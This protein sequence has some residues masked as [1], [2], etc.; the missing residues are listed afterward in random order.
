MKRKGNR[1]RGSIKRG[2]Q[3]RRKRR[4]HA[5]PRRLLR[6]SG[7]GRRKGRKGRKGYRRRLARA[8]TRKRAE[9]KGFDAVRLRAGNELFKQQLPVGGRIIDWFREIFKLDHDEFLW[10]LYRQILQREPDAAGFQDHKQRLEDGTAKVWI[11]ASLIQSQEAESVFDRGPSGEANTAAHVFQNL[12]PAAELDFIHAAHVHLLQREPE[13]ER[14]ASYAGALRQGLQRRIWIARLL[15]SDEAQSLLVGA[16]APAPAAPR[17]SGQ[18]RNIGI[19]LCFGSQISMDG[20]GIG[21]FIVR[22]SE[23]LLALDKG[24][25]LHVTTTEANFKETSAVFHY[26]LERYKG[27]VHIHHSDSMDMINRNVPA[28]V[29]IVPYIGMALAQYL[30]KPT[31]IC[32][33]DLVYLHFPELYAGNQ[34]HYQ[35][36]HAIAQKITAKAAA[37]VFDSE[38]TRRHEGHKFLSLP[39]HQTT[40]IRFAAPREEYSAFGVVSEDTIR[41]KYKLYGPYMVFPSVIRLHKNHERLIDAFHRFRLTEIGAASGLKLVFTDVLANRP[42]QQEI[43]AALNAIGDPGIRTSIQFLGRIP[44]GELPSLYKYASGTIVPTLFEGSCPFPILESLLM[45][46]PVAYGRLEVVEEVIADS[47]SFATFNPRDQLEM[48]DAIARLWLQGKS[49]VPEQKA[50]LGGILHRNW[51]DVA[52]DYSAII[53]NIAASTP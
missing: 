16:G 43:T 31:I 37:V 18:Y 32:L 9:K 27:R 5:K 3:S 11:A 19:F 53:D 39:A 21:R 40:V 17:S 24:Y 29:W 49:V 42:R 41:S 38:F 8:R 47:S 30:Q 4:K 2:S 45:D 50:A 15:L 52:R 36:V 51:I 48:A 25:A 14:V 20:E 13:A 10:E 28:D 6:R 46:T 34:T 1:K 35:Y 26:L 22:L 33:H 7:K 23:G 44:S 12:F